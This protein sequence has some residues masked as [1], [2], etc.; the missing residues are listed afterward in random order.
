VTS[1]PRLGRAAFAL[2]G[3]LLLAWVIVRQGPAE[4]LALLR[5]VGW[6]VVAVAPIYAAFQA[7]R[8][9][10][11]W[12]CVP[13]RRAVGYR[14]ALAV[15]VSGEAVQFL[16]ATG[17]FLAEPTKAWLL[18]RAGL[19]GA[20]G[21][22][23][24]IAEYLVN[25]LLGS[26]LLAGAMTWLL[27]QVVLPDALV[28][29]AWILLAASVMFFGVA[30]VAI[31]RRIYLI[32]MMLRG[33]GVLPAVGRRLRLDQGAVRRF[34]DR[35][36]AILRED[37]R[38]LSAVVLLDGA[39]HL[40]LVL[41]L[42]AILSLSGFAVSPLLALL[43]ESAAKFVSIAFFFIPAQL[44]ASEG[45]LATIVQTVGLPGAVGVAA[46]LVRRVRSLIVSVVGVAALSLLGGR[47]PFAPA[48]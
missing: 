7:A 1:H 24:T 14:R 11:L 43:V 20:E 42:W 6:G 3:V 19:S 47:R 15:R 31:H 32:G 38:R 39:G 5:E 18:A 33:V 34:E 46:A 4:I 10:A 22:A 26:I 25:T 40:L 23:A 8:A 41:E 48:P 17:P 21:F 13:D 36:L 16:T 12:F 29:T 37:P 9:G 28:A 44:G 35:L 2:V 45:V 30:V 27:T